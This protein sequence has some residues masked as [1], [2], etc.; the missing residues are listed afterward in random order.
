MRLERIERLPRKDQ[1]FILKFLDTYL[2]KA[3]GG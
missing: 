1:E 3:E 2:E